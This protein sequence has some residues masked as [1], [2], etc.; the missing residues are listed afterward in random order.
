MPADVTAKLEISA[1]AEKV[2]EMISDL[3]RMGEWSPENEGGEWMRGATGPSPGARFRGVNRYGGKTWKSVATV[4][5]AEPGRRFSFKISAMGIPVSEWSYDFEPTES[6]CVVT[7]SWSDR[8]PGVFKPIAA[9][10]TG[11]EDRAEHNRSTMEQT[12]AN[13]AAAAEAESS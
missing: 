9:K 7:E 10:A 4:V 13:L 5:D 1:P 2:W 11:I 6:G 8:R 12:L 3:T